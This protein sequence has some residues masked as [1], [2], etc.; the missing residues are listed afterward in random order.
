MAVSIIGP[1]FYAW[2][3]D[4]GKPLA[5]GKVYTYA[6]GTN[7]P[8][9]TWQS[10]DGAVANTNP[11]I[12]NGAGYADIYLRGRYKIVVKDEDDVEVWTADP[13]SDASS[14]LQPWIEE[15]AATQV[16]PNQFKVTGNKT[17]VF[18]YGRSV[19]MDDQVIVYGTVLKSEYLSGETFVTIDAVDSLTSQ[20][21]RAW[22]SLVDLESLLPVLKDE[23][24]TTLVDAVTESLATFQPRMEQR[25][26][27][28]LAASGY[29]FLATY[30][31]GIEITEYN[32]VVRDAAG[33]LWRA[34]ATTDLPYTTDGT[35][36]P[37]GGAFVSAGDAVLRND[38][39]SEPANGQGAM[40]VRG[41]VIYV[42]TIADLQ[43]LDTSELVDGQ[44]A[45]VSGSTFKFIGG[46][47][48][49][50]G[51]VTA[52]AYGATADGVPDDHAALQAYADELDTGAISTM[53]LPNHVGTY[54][55]SDKVVIKEPGVRIFGDRG[56]TY[57][58]GLG[59]PGNILLMESASAGLDLGAYRT[60]ANTTN[61]SDEWTVEGLG[62]LTEKYWSVRDQNAIEF[63]PQR[64]GPDRGLRLS[65]V[66]ARNMNAGLYIPPTND[67]V[68]VSIAT[69]NI[70]NCNLSNN[71][72]GFLCDGS[73]QGLRVVNNQ[74]EQ[75]S[76]EAIKAK[77]TSSVTIQDNMLEGCG[78]SEGGTIDLLTRK[79][80]NKMQVTIKNNY[81]EASRGPFLIR[82]ENTASGGFAEIG[83][84]FHL[85]SYVDNQVVLKGIW[86]EVRNY[87][88]YPITLDSA[89]VNDMN[90]TFFGIHDHFKLAY[91]ENGRH[92]VL[93]TDF[94][95]FLKPDGTD[96]WV[97]STGAMGTQRLT[98]F[99]F[100]DVYAGTFSMTSSGF[101]FSGPV[102]DG[103]LF[104]YAFM[105]R[106]DAKGSNAQVSIIDSN[107]GDRFSATT[108]ALATV[109]PGK[110]A[111]CIGQIR[112]SAT[113]S[114]AD[115]RFRIT[116]GNTTG[117]IAT[118]A[119]KRI[120]GGAN[121]ISLT[122][123]V[124]VYPIIPEWSAV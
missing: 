14:L 21:S 123:P 68:T 13:V 61:P 98:P 52:Q 91:P 57:E 12:L 37:E 116:G 87:D 119:L 4:T 47:W 45:N 18:R 6:A 55:I 73:V 122:N 31:A 58:R 111:L 63:T 65:K 19:K 62:F 103:D 1:K 20:L 95:R 84:N 30:Q 71:R 92:S 96:G 8:K 114:T 17:D 110:W 42:N 43:A 104:L 115:Y 38:L 44:I 2:D 51:P 10:E 50:I 32:K 7:T 48:N 100:K 26:N 29:E 5:F 34:A 89:V 97:S 124:D 69:L 77:A 25:F 83:P 120:P 93:T 82:L 22:A 94:E 67:N 118:L 108:S 64:N 86:N 109:T 39:M 79:N 80:G 112:A 99:G 105:F 40:L 72:Y 9:A 117:E 53:Y 106:T 46:T 24:V 33:Q 85:S 54:R 107:Y 56:P 59:R 16:A 70:E 41:A 90:R 102:E 28:L 15:T 81:F 49:P 121:T 11:V 60:S 66:S 36:L 113:F 35:G 76:A 88:I 3:S 27:L 23:A 74:I 101:T 75:C 78:G